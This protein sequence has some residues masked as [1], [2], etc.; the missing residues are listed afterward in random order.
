VFRGK[1]LAALNAQG[2]TAPVCLPERWVVDCKAMGNGHKALVYLGRYLY[3]GVIQERDIV[4]CADSQVT[5]RYRDSTSGK[6]TLRTVSGAHFL[7]LV[8][9]QVLPRGLR[10]SRNF[11]L[12]HPNCKHRQR[13]AQLRLTCSAPAAT[14][15]RAAGAP[16]SAAALPVTPP[17]LS[18]RP[19][20]QCR[21]CGSAM[22]IVRQRI[23][24]P[25]SHGSPAGPPGAVREGHIH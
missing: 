21:C 16:S 20:L 24:A 11:G 18:A 10:R 5:F 2:L 1:L 12:L 15:R 4:R 23:A 6:N 7:W 25:P 17:T 14:V 19:K 8:L 9:Q 22:Q 13:L 3:C